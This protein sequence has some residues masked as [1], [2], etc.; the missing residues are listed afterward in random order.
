MQPELFYQIAL[1]L[2]PQIGP[3]QARL[4]LEKFGNAS[5]VFKTKSSILEHTEGIGPVR[6][7]EIRQFR[8]FQRVEKEME[9]IRKYQIKPL[10][11]NCNEYPKRLL[12]CYD[13]PTLLYYKGDADLNAVKTVGIIGTRKNSDYGRQLTETLVE[14]LAGSD[15]LIISGLAFGIDVIAHKASLKNQLKTIGVMAHGLDIL[16]PPQ[17][18]TLAK[19]MLQ[20]GGGLLTEFISGTPPD[21]HNFPN[22]NRIV[23]GLCDVVVV[24]ESGEKGGSMVT[25]SL[26][27]GYNRE[28]MAYPGRTIDNRSAG[29]NQLLQQQ[30]AQLITG[31]SDLLKYMNW[32]VQSSRQTVYQQSLFHQ[33]GEFERKLVECIGSKESVELDELLAV[34]PVGNSVLAGALLGLELK[35]I[36]KKLPGQRFKLS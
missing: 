15:P 9:F 33:L 12:H 11:I 21:K 17:H 22:R 14:G 10:F 16:Y 30:R 6:A 28:V 34:L 7:S 29:C 3:V 8:D 26:A 35:G 4:L 32:E 2:I 13:P 20:A 31:P 24:I 23:A 19:E 5:E 36:V 1:S 18:S 25:A 27:S